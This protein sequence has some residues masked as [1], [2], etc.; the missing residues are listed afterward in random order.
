MNGS[1]MKGR[2]SERRMLRSRVAR[3]G[4]TVVSPGMEASVVRDCYMVKR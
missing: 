1:M 3:V 4:F 2:L